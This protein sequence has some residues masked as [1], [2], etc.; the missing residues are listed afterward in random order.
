MNI[1]INRSESSSIDDKANNLFFCMNIAYE[2]V[3]RCISYICESSSACISSTTTKLCPL[4]SDG[5]DILL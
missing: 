1:I 5:L 4:L 3:K 2:E